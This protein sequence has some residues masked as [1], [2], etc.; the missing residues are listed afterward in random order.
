MCLWFH[1]GW[2][3]ILPLAMMVFCILMCIFMRGHVSCGSA[4]CC[5][6]RHS[7]SD[8]ENEKRSYVSR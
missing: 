7:K 2:I 3:F 4:M 6:H 1:P 5:S 8:A